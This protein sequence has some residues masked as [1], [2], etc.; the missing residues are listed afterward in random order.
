MSQGENTLTTNPNI[1]VIAAPSLEQVLHFQIPFL[2]SSLHFFYSF[3][4]IDAYFSLA[5]SCH[6][7]NKRLQC[8]KAYLHFIE[9]FTISHFDK[10]K[11]SFSNILMMYRIPKR[12]QFV[13]YKTIQI[14]IS[15]MKRN[16]RE[17]YV[18]R[19]GK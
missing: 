16:F 7:S 6:L 15:L 3:F 11:P 17:R 12:I 10:K 19:Q 9:A 18:E 13:I 5:I 2:S 1:W 4:R 8:F 14:I